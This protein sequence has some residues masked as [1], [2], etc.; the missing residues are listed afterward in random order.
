VKI[1]DIA[2][3]IGMNEVKGGGTDQLTRF[4][5][6]NR[7]NKLRDGMARMLTEEFAD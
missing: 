5:T 3:F 2:K 7:I 1:F 6:C 4:V